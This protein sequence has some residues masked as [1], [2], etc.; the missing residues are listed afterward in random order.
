MA[1]SVFAPALMSYVGHWSEQT[2]IAADVHAPD[3]D[4]DS[5]QEDPRAHHLISR[6]GI[7]SVRDEPA[8]VIAA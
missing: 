7:I 8:R 5:G 2:G 4:D 6:G 3:R 1:C